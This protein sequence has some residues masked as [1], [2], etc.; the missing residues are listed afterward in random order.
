MYNGNHKAMIT[1]EEYDRVQIILGRNG[2]PRHQ[3]HESAYTGIMRCSVCGSMYT[4][5]EKFKIVLGTGELKTYAYCNCTRKKKG[6]K[7]KEKPIPLKELEDQIDIELERGTILPIFQ[8][9]ALEIL[10]RDND[11]EIE[12]RTKIYEAQHKT[13]AET[14]KELDTLT[15]MRYRELI[16][17]ET[18]IKERDELKTKIAKLKSALRETESRAEKWLE[19]S[20]RTFNFACYARKEFTTTKSLERKREIFSALGQNFLVKDKKVLITPNERFVP[21]EKA[22]PALEAEYT[23]LELDKTLTDSMRNELFAQLIPTWGA[24]RDLNPD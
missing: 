6:V 9:W 15:K 14:Q 19:L 5:T 18:F 8:K 11:K 23:R 17:D 2:K 13:L 12:D 4:V 22:Y 16:D 10:N 1:L 21:I 3:T 20:E 7:C 24:Y